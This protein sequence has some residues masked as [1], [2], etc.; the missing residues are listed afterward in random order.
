MLHWRMSRRFQPCMHGL[1]VA[2]YSENLQKVREICTSPTRN[3]ELSLLDRGK[4]SALHLAVSTGNV[5]IVEYLLEQPGLDIRAQM[6]GGE[7]AL[8]LSCQI[9]FVPLKIIELLIAKDPEVVHW[10]DRRTFSPMQKALA[11]G[12]PD[13]IRILIEQGGV[14]PNH[15]DKDGCHILFYAVSNFDMET[16]HFL[17]H[18][19][20]CDMTHRN[21]NGQTA[22]ETIC[23]SFMLGCKENLIINMFHYTYTE[24]T[25]PILLGQLL[26]EC[27]MGKGGIGSGIDKFRLPKAGNNTKILPKSTQ[28]SETPQI[29]DPTISS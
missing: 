25:T 15:E 23:T 8:S 12:R 29:S 22:F 10:V 11:S 4:M 18:E 1:H 6:V 7:T 3:H 2:C 26:Q 9:Q 28:Q 5:K 13:I 16:I 14:D 19:T 27:G 21:K 20:N 17:K 24:S